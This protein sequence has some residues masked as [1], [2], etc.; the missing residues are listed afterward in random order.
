MIHDSLPYEE[1][2][3]LETILRHHGVDPRGDGT[4]LTKDLAQLG[5]WIH[6]A[7]RSKFDRNQKPPFLIALLSMMGIYGKKDPDRDQS[8]PGPA[9]R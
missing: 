2:H 9:V 5:N 1:Q 4:Q 6:Q 8:R 7:E 3:A